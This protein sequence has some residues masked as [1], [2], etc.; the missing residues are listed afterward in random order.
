[1]KNQILFIVL[2]CVVSSLTAQSKQYL[3]YSTIDKRGNTIS[4]Y[5]AIKIS[6]E[7][8][9]ALALSIANNRRGLTAEGK[10]LYQSDTI[11]YL[12]IKGVLEEITG[13]NFENKIFL[14]EYTYLNDPCTSTG[15]IW[16]RAAIKRRKGFTTRHKKEIEKRNKEVLILN[17]FEKGISLSNSPGKKKEYFYTDENNVLKENLFLNPTTCGSFAL[18]KPNGEVLVYN[19]ESSAWFMEQHLK[20]QTWKLFFPEE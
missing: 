6:A 13:K 4:F 1:M 9:Q 7:E 10:P 17:F 5:K 14:L 19:G 8:E 12:E 20:P 18:I 3:H 11:N 2:A 16:N 15:N